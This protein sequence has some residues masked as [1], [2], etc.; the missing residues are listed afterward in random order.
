MMHSRNELQIHETLKQAL[1]KIAYNKHLQK[2][3]TKNI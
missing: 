2:T 1:F 3:L